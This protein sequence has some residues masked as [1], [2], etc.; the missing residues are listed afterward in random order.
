MFHSLLPK[1]TMVIMDHASFHKSAR[2]EALPE[3]AGL[4]LCYLPAYSPDLNPIEH[5]WSSLKKHIRSFLAHG[6]SLDKSI[7]FAFF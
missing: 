4:R 5:M 6:L 1:G 3:Q 7:D 2:V